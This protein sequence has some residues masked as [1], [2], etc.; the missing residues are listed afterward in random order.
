M[1]N[2]AN[3]FVADSFGFLTIHGG[4]GN[5]KTTALMGIVNALIEKGIEARYITAS[6]LLAY[7]RET[8]NGESKQSDYDRLHEL[9]A[10]PVLCID[11]MDKLRGSEYSREIQQELMNTRYRE[12][13]S[14]GTVLAWNGDFETI[15]MPA[16]TSRA[17]EFVVIWNRDSDIRP[18]IGMS[19]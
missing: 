17:S 7:L 19:K 9:A 1:V 15:N 16:V 6:N 4:F 3:N 13:G 11:E 14:L 8:F 2:A 12:A 18:E 5:G 10:V